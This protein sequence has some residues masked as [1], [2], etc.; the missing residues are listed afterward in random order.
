[1]SWRTR[2][3]F[4]KLISQITAAGSFP[5]RRQRNSRRTRSWRLRKPQNFSQRWT[6]SSGE[7]F[8]ILLLTPPL[9]TQLKTQHHSAFFRATYPD[10]TVAG[11]E[12]H[13]RTGYYFGKEGPANL[14]AL[15]KT[16]RAHISNAEAARVE[17]PVVHTRRN[18][19]RRYIQNRTIQ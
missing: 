1:M 7:T 16:I 9:K 17:F 18:I 8:A 14:G 11:P 13:Y 10:L 3:H 15:L 4:S 5:V 12:R 19:L 6:N 2:F